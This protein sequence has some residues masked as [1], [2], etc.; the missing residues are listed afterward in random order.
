MHEW[1]KRFLL[2]LQLCCPYVVRE[3]DAELAERLDTQI[4]ESLRL[5][6]ALQIPFENEIAPGSA[7]NERVIALITSLQAQ[8][9]ILFE[10]FSLFGLSVEIPE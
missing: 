1:S 2:H 5:A 7:G 10:V 8:E 4:N 3:A 9:S 6:D